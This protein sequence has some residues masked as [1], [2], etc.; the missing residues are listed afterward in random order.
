LRFDPAGGIAQHGLNV[1][2]GGPVC[3]KRGGLGRDADVVGELAH[4]VAVPRA[5]GV[6]QRLGGIEHGGGDSGVHAKLLGQQKGYCNTDGMVLSCA[7]PRPS[8]PLGAEPSPAATAVSARA[9]GSEDGFATLMTGFGLVPAELDVGV[10][11]CGD[12]SGA[13]GSFNEI[14]PTIA[15]TYDKFSTSY[16]DEVVAAFDGYALTTN[17]QTKDVSR[18]I[19]VAAIGYTSFVRVIN[20]GTV[21]AA[22]TGQFVNEDGTTS[23]SGVIVA[24]LKAGGSKTLT[25]TEI[26]TAM[27]V[28]VRGARSRALPYQIK[29]M[30]AR[31][32]GYEQWSRTSVRAR[33][34]YQS[35]FA[36]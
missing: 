26:E 24:T 34:R 7:S 14:K 9:V 2:V 29:P 19:P 21:D 32:A 8:S 27:G 22:V 18:Y 20:T 23:A 16:S 25:S 30:Q 15:F 10:F 4:D 33:P 11:L 6:V 36:G 1:A 31:I 3:V 5:G 35:E 28:E 12:Y 13:T 17:G